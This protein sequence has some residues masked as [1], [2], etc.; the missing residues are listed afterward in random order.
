MER[1]S[2]LAEKFSAFREDFQKN[3]GYPHT[4]LFFGFFL[5]ITWTH[6]NFSSPLMTVSSQPVEFAALA[7]ESSL[8]FNSITLLVCAFFHRAVE[9]SLFSSFVT[10]GSAFFCVVGTLLACLPMESVVSSAA[11]VVTGSLSTG[12]GSAFLLLMLGAIFTKH[13]KHMFTVFSAIL[14]ANMAVPILSLLPQPI[15][16]FIVVALPPLIIALLGAS[17]KSTGGEAFSGLVKEDLAGTASLLA[18][19]VVMVLVFY[20]SNT[21]AKKLYQG[22]GV[23]S[24]PVTLIATSA[25]IAIALAFSCLSARKFNTVS[26]YRVIFLFTLVSF[27]SI[28]LFDGNYSYSYGIICVSTAVFRSLLFICEC[29]IC[30]KTGLSPVLVFGLGEVVKRIPN[31]AI[32]GIQEVTPF[33]FSFQE[34]G[35]YL[36]WLLAFVIFLTVVYVLIFTEQ[37]MRLLTEFD[38]TMSVDEQFERRL[39]RIAEKHSLTERETEIFS[40]FVHG[41][42]VPHIAKTL[43]LSQGTVNVHA[44]KIYKKL[45]VHS[46][47][48]L[49]DLATNDEA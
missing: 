12:I 34:I 21:L 9:R 2:A 30:R 36:F 38:R 14:S 3:R 23:E 45:D 39:N 42:S 15:L 40:M 25:L 1:D 4:T 27:L 48:E 13:H 28:P 41:R 35:D 32:I 24:E 46:R 20:S 44:K 22:T 8:V 26:L 6:F 11:R 19:F 5:F 10:I 49:I 16:L 33:A 7:Y 43:Y 18:R 17:P 29:Q 47:Q 31:L 37:D